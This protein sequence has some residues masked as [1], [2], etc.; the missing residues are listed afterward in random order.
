M[1]ITYYTKNK[2]GISYVIPALTAMQGKLDI[3][4]PQSDSIIT[5]N[6]ESPVTVT[7]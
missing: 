3:P 7:T 4:A 2:K 6:S 1:T 5:L